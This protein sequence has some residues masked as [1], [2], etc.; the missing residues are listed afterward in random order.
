MWVSFMYNCCPRYCCTQNSNLMF[1][2]PTQSNVMYIVV[3]DLRYTCIV[4]CET[5]LLYWF[6]LVGG[7]TP[8][9][10]T[11]QK[12]Q[13]TTCQLW[14][15][16]SLFS[17]T[18]SMNV[19]Q[20][21]CKIDVCFWVNPLVLKQSSSFNRSISRHKRQLVDNIP[22][23]FIHLTSRGC[24]S[25]SSSCINHTIIIHDLYLSWSDKMS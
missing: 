21:V 17:N 25:Y 12:V 11:T 9:K 20:L 19:T 23:L 14:T 15:I 6:L 5:A 3:H 16:L 10:P 18:I 13:P 24:K 4:E 22:L 7:R 1:Y 2:I 8:S